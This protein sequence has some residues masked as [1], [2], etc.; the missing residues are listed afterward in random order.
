MPEP[1]LLL[2]NT[3][4]KS[5]TLYGFSNQ[6]I[7][8]FIESLNTGFLRPDRY[9][10]P[11]V[12]K[13]CGDLTDLKLGFSVHGLMVTSG[14]CLDTFMGNSLVAMYMKCGNKEMARLVFDSMGERSVVSSNTL[15]SGYFRNGCAEEAL[16]LFRE[17]IDMSVEIDSATVVSVLPA[18]G[19][20][21]D[22]EYGKRVHRL[23]EERDLGR[24]IAV[25]NALLDMYVK[26]GDMVEARLLFNKMSEK[27]VVTWTTMIHGYISNNDV[28]E[29]MRLCPP[30]QFEGVR[31]NAVTTALL[32][33]GCSNLSMLKDGMCLHGWAL[34]QNLELD[35]SVE[36]SLIDMYAN[37]NCIKAS[38]KVFLN[39]SR[40]RRAPWNAMFS[41]LVHNNLPR[42]AIVLFKKMIF[43]AVGP[44]NA[45]LNSLL[46]SYAL[47]ADIQQAMNIHGY[48]L[49]SG[50]FSN[51]QVSTCFIDIY[52][53]CGHLEYSY[54]VFDGISAKDKD[55][56][57]WTAII[58]GY[59]MH[60]NG[61]IAVS[62]F[63]KMVQSGIEPNEITFTSVLH[64]CSHS[65]LVDEGLNL[66]K[67]M[68]ELDKNIARPNHYTCIVDLLGRADRLDEA[69]ELIRTMPIEPH[70]AV[71]GALLGACMV[72]ENVELGEIAAEKLYELEPENTGNYV[73]MYNIYSSVGRWRDAEKIRERLEDIGLRKSPAHSLIEVRNL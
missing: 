42:E 38:Y 2:Y 65:G 45:T 48:L 7:E 54:R 11:Y 34:R 33:S 36:T 72:H 32:L 3:I 63:K 50:F 14:V 46:P 49:R 17:M 73:L 51:V 19:L 60:G 67:F 13:A 64:A 5:C 20:L 55:I 43:E 15:I 29:G 4:I 22:L 53:K 21:K 18:C 44:E 12:I 56:I 9:S 28:K 35:V 52:S 1:T 59:G 71:W 27:D 57:C 31:P 40:K 37:C 68:L 70:H 39:T 30:M 25:K 24:K 23:V 61:E 10:F 41:G 26:C 66:F 6:A 69:Y 58:A 8:I 16:A 62:L 47:L